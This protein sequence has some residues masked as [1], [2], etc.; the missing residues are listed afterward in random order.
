MRKHPPYPT[1]PLHPSSNR[2][3]LHCSKTDAVNYRRHTARSPLQY[4]R[5]LVTPRVYVL[6]GETHTTLPHTPVYTRS[7]THHAPYSL[8]PHLGTVHSP[9]HS[10]I[11]FISF[12]FEIS[13]RK[14]TRLPDLLRDRGY[15]Q[16]VVLHNE[17][18]AVGTYSVIA[19]R[20]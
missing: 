13:R 6:R 3:S 5:E 1:P 18:Y 11:G 4:L 2:A 10:S 19:S 17:I 7:T 16:T 15:F 12:S 14:W 8:L 9:T 20:C